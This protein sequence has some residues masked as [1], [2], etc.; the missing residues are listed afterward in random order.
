MFDFRCATFIRSLR[1]LKRDA[2][3][4]RVVTH[5]NV[6]PV[7]ERSTFNDV[8][9]RAVRRSR[10]TRIT[11]PPVPLRAAPKRRISARRVK[12]PTP[13]NADCV[14][15]LGADSDTGTERQKRPAQRRQKASTG[16]NVSG[17]LRLCSSA[18]GSRVVNLFRK[19]GRVFDD[20]FRGTRQ[21]RFFRIEDVSFT[22]ESV[23]G[24]SSYPRSEDSYRQ[25]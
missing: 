3:R 6:D 11:T 15:N 8:D 17:A 10:F 4:C 21:I 20:R 9:P 25:G 22:V 7:R 5:A 1:F 18:V 14:T 12:S 16:K 13:F 24:A 23:S 19:K 2:R